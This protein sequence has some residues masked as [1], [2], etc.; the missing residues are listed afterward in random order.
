MAIE[1]AVLTPAQYLAE[2]R[3]REE[4]YEYEDGKLIQLPEY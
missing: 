4:K 1:T 3:R 2:E